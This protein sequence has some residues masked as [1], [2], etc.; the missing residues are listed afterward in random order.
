[1]L[2][3]FFLP[4]SN[5]LLSCFSDDSIFAWECDTLFCKY[6]LPLPDSG[7]RI[8]YKA[9]AVTLWV[10]TGQPSLF[11]HFLYFWSWH[12][13][14]LWYSKSCLPA[15]APLFCVDSDGKSLASGGRSNLLH[16]WCLESRQLVRVIQMPIQVRTI[17]QL[18][19]LPDSFDGGASQVQVSVFLWLCSLFLK[20]WFSLS[21]NYV[22]DLPLHS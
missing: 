4:L 2:Q 16:L 7:P 15:L 3:V 5:T 21:E 1:M 14:A 12:F 22:I 18:E 17:R 9:F 6:Q 19:F 8:S 10:F 11:P 13:T 20:V